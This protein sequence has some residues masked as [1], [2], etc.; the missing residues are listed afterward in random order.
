[1]GNNEPIVSE[2]FPP[3][4][5]VDLVKKDEVD[6]HSILI[7]NLLKKW[8][9][10]I[11]DREDLDQFFKIFNAV[12]VLLSVKVSTLLPGFGEVEETRESPETSDED[13]NQDWVYTLRD[14]LKEKENL[15]SKLFSRPLFTPDAILELVE[16]DALYRLA[17][18]VI[19][20]YR[21]RPS[22]EWQ[23]ELVDIKK[24]RKELKK[25][26][27]ERGRIN[28]KMVLEKEETLIDVIITFVIVLELCKQA[29]VRLI[30]RRAFD[31]I[32]VVWR[33]SE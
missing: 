1:M 7:S 10:S 28:L 13:V 18:E 17:E 6:I 25:E 16:P 11:E 4:E 15:A 26:I 20:R 23:K 14:E 33:G 30:Q 9:E 24:K 32:W 5:I 27:E 21:E 29:V 12:I 3:D 22:I 2:S 8:V 31:D 19:A